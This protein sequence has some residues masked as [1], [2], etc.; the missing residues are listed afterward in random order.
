[1][2]TVVK[3]NILE[4]SQ[5][6]PLYS[7]TNLL[8]ECLMRIIELCRFLVSPAEKLIVMVHMSLV[9]LAT[10]RSSLLVDHDVG[11]VDSKLPRINV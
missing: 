3:Y 11:S 8:S 7:I 2:E 10:I 6:S 5:S 9:S 4:T 1:M